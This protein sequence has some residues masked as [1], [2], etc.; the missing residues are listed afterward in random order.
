MRFA[1]WITL[2][3]KSGINRL[4]Q[5][6]IGNLLYVAAVS[7]TPH[8]SKMPSADSNCAELF[9]IG[10]PRGIIAWQPGFDD[11]RL[12]AGDRAGETAEWLYSI[13]NVDNDADWNRTNTPMSK[14]ERARERE[15]LC[16]KLVKHMCVVA[17]DAHG[18][19]VPAG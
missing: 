12:A 4:Q 19:F 16:S 3:F 6:P 8:L 14:R 5:Y 9:E 11:P 7:Q 10:I 18:D 15:P 13:L 1:A 2:L 17:L